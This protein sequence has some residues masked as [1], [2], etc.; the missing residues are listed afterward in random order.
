[1]LSPSAFVINK[2]SANSII[3]LF[4]PCNSSPA[5][6]SISNKKKSTKLLAVVSLCPTPTVSIRIISKPAASHK[7]ILSLVLL[8]TPPNVPPLG[9]GRINAL[10]FADSSCIRLLSPNILPWVLSLVGSIANTATFIPWLVSSFPKAS[11]KE[12]FPTPGTPVTPTLID[13]P[14]CGKHSDSSSCDCSSCSGK[15]LSNRVIPCPKA[16]RLPSIIC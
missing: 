13:F 1:M 11:I 9:L 4:I 2:A 14:L 8:A 7:I 15:V 3:P 16:V 6:D 5:P 10:L 12:L